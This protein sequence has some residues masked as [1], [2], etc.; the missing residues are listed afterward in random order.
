MVKFCSRESKETDSREQPR[1]KPCKPG[2]DQVLPSF[3]VIF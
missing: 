1:T 3:K 2:T